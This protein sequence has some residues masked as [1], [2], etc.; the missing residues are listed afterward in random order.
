MNKKRFAAVTICLIAA[1]SFILAACTPAASTGTTFRFGNGETYIFDITLEKHGA[2]NNQKKGPDDQ[3]YTKDFQLLPDDY[4]EIRP[5]DVK[6]TYR[7]D[8][9]VAGEVCTITTSQT[10]FAAYSSETGAAEYFL[11]RLTDEQKAIVV[12][13]DSEI[14]DGFGE[15]LTVL[16]SVITTE[17][18]T[19][20]KAEQ[21]PSSSK[22]TVKGYY[23]GLK[24]QE[25]SDY[26]AECQYDFADKAQA[27]VTLKKNGGTPQENTYD[28]S[29]NS[30]INFI[31]V[32]QILT[33]SRSLN[34]KSGAFQDSPSVQVYDPLTNRTVTATFALT[35]SQRA[36]FT[37][38]GQDF[39][40]VANALTVSLNNV[41]AYII[42]N[43]P[44]D[45]A[46]IPVNDMIGVNP[47]HTV[48]RFQNGYL[49][50]E[51]SSYETDWVTLYTPP[52]AEEE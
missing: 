30:A 34:K 43:V 20:T 48:T 13:D 15:G 50:Y 5:A 49:A 52:T 29:Y 51:I 16:K 38:N 33:Y 45:T 23:L 14:P 10:V 35:P 22:K 27:K 47:K 21:L 36:L 37:N 24:Q 12:P 26:E 42:Y 19:N 32:N 28:L 41:S 1:F 3:T 31:D 40:A 9:A 44:A 4:D 8:I 6:G 25:I 7:M 17:T 11:S 2:E 18:V 46:E 39:F